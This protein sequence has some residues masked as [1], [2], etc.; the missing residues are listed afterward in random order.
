MITIE[1]TEAAC[2]L[3]FLGVEDVVVDISS[4]VVV[5]VAEVGEEGTMEGVVIMAVVGV[6][7]EGEVVGC[8]MPGEDM[9]MMTG[10]L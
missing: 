5:D 1:C 9:D 8:I 7:T 3:V 4:E 6:T 10:N 2:V